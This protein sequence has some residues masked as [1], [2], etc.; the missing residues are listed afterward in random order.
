MDVAMAAA[1]I[2]SVASFLSQQLA[3]HHQAETTSGESESSRELG[4]ALLAGMQAAA[5]II[6][7]EQRLRK[8]SEDRAN[9]LSELT[10]R[11]R[12]KGESVSPEEVKSVAVKLTAI[13]P[14]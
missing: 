2:S 14:S 1:V 13:A 10:V 3:K 4:L 12:E 11:L 7:S 6:G 9:E 8:L 5:T